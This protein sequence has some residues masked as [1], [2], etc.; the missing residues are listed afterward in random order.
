VFGVLKRVDVPGPGNWPAS[1]PG[2]GPGKAKFSVRSRFNSVPLPFLI[3][4]IVF[5][6]GFVSLATE[7]LLLRM[8]SI[9]LDSSVQSF[10]IVLSTF[11][12]GFA[13]GSLVFAGIAAGSRRPLS[14]I[15]GL[16][17][18][19]AALLAVI[20]PLLDHL[21]LFY[22]DLIRD[23][24]TAWH[25]TVFIRYAVVIGLLLPFTFLL[26]GVF[27]IAVQLYSGKLEN[28]GDSVGSLYAWNTV[29]GILGTVLTGL[30]ILPYL[31]SWFGFVFIV[32]V[33][34]GMAVLVFLLSTAGQS[35]L[36][37]AW[38][39]ATLV[40]VIV[41][42]VTAGPWRPERLIVWWGGEVQDAADILLYEEGRESN[43]AVV[44]RDDVRSLFV[45][46]KLVASDQPEARRHL[47]LLGHIPLLLHPTPK[48]VLVIGLATGTTLNATLSH[49]IDTAEC[50]DINPLM[51]RAAELFRK[52]NQDVLNRPEVK[53]V[54]ADA[55]RYLKSRTG[56]F[57]C[58]TTDPIH[59]ADANSNNLYSLE[60]FRLASD[61][62]K[63]DGLMCQWMS[64]ADLRPTEIKRIIATFGA[65]FP[66]V[67]LWMPTL[68]DLALVGSKQAI[69]IDLAQLQR[70]FDDV[71][72]AAAVARYLGE[73][74]I[75]SFLSL[76]LMGDEQL[77][78]MTAGVTLNTDDRPILEYEAPKY[79]WDMGNLPNLYYDIYPYWRGSFDQLWKMI[80]PAEDAERQKGVL[81]ADYREERNHNLEQV[82][83][84]IGMWCQFLEE[85]GDLD[86]ALVQY[87]RMFSLFPET[88]NPALL[89]ACIGMSVIHEKLGN[90]RLARDYYETA[91]SMAPDE[92]MSRNMTAQAFAARHLYGRAQEE[93]QAILAKD[94]G[95]E[96][97]TY[98]LQRL[99]KEGLLSG[100]SE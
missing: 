82:A 98:Y 81:Q 57:D 28:I 92:T 84:Y 99:K 72:T 34:S 63:S 13:L 42:A 97:A 33:M 14:W 31:G 71:T 20:T 12:A 9:S 78:T 80:D 17:L 55:R 36:L 10:G 2:G 29:G 3:T 11:I 77:R 50:V 66:H 94:P 22:Y 27:P 35:V 38:P 83:G 43:V 56:V 54:I 8:L 30:L 39:A 48:Q 75:E 46:K 51:L 60:F 86:G 44:Q 64:T 79:L 6:S 40:F 52:E 24:G 18:A 59:P 19:S 95:N 96:E 1:S 68:G 32:L 16:L 69:R 74:S 65:V 67:S 89:D 61:A 88:L 49:G 4:A 25:S 7:V 53:V 15:G 5:T 90:T 26:G 85:H 41:V 73:A 58:I 91:I 93:W 100:G 62:L 87:E 23:Y 21:P 37:R 76:F 45:G 70:R 47:G